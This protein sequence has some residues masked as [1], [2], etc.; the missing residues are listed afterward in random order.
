MT[1]SIAP[2]VHILVCHWI[3]DITECELENRTISTM[4][5]VLLQQL[6]FLFRNNDSPVYQQIYMCFLQ[7]GWVCVFILLCRITI[8]NNQAL[9]PS[10]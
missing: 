8:V 6:N 4:I 3:Y 7:H 2:E 9:T 5:S 1:S 10:P